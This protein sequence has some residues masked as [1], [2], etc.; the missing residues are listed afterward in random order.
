[1]P[2]EDEKYVSAQNVQM[3]SW[4]KWCVIKKLICRLLLIVSLT[5]TFASFSVNYSG[6][7]MIICFREEKIYCLHAVKFNGLS[8]YN[9]LSL[10][11]MD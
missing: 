11:P 6:K 2:E 9:V 1:M 7:K 5:Y 4:N 3:Y 8:L 10:A